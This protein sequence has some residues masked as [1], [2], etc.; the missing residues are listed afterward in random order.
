MILADITWTQL[1]E[2]A[3]AIGTLGGF[4]LGLAM[5]NKKTPIKIDQEPT[6]EFRK[7]AKRFNHDLSESRH[8]DHER[9]LLALESWRDEFIPRMEQDRRELVKENEMRASRIHEHI[10][11]DRVAMDT[12]IENIFDRILATLRNMGK[13]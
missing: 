6:P 8:I 7:A 3:I 12:K 9:R 1:G 2:I 11:K 4:I 10:E 5:L 13:L